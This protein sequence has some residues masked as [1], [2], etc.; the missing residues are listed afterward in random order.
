LSRAP[1]FVGLN[2]EVKVVPIE[3]RRAKSWPRR[4]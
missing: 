3:D 4:S 1:D 2:P